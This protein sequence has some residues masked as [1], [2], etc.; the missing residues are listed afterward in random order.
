MRRTKTLLAAAAIVALAAAAPLA[1]A[2][3][4]TPTLKLTHT[5]VGRILTAK[6][7]TMYAFTRDKRNKDVCQKI[8]TCLA[9]W[10]PLY[11]KHKPKAGPGVKASLLGTI[12]LKNGKRQVTYKKH[13]LY[14]YTALPKGTSYV[15]FSMFGGRWDA[16]NARGGLVK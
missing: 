7:D 10:K 16:V 4:R 8:K 1:L 13:P 6:G 12:K 14:I 11:T 15:G 3:G 2:S 5:S 9:V